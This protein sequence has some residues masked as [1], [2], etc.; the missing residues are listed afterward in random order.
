[1]GVLPFTQGAHGRHVVLGRG[2]KEVRSVGNGVTG[3]GNS[4]YKSHEVGA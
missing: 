2:P 1:M 4:K 3:K